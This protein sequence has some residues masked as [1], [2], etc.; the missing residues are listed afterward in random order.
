MADDTVVDDL[1]ALF[2]GG[3]R[4]ELEAEILAAKLELAEE[5]ADYWRSISP[6]DEGTYKDSIEVV[7]DGDNVAVVAQDEKAN[8][9]EY[10][11]VDTPEF[12]CRARTEE[13]FNQ[14]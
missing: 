11:S 1:L 4:G 8:I 7:Q 5:V 13:Y 3:D 10:G 2:D 6:E 9:I 14:S 12:A